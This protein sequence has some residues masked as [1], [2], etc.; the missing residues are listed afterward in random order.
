MKCSK[1]GFDLKDSAKFCPKCGAEVASLK[2]YCAQCGGELEAGLQFCPAC[3]KKVGNKKP[4]FDYKKLTGIGAGVVI[5]AVLALIVGGI[6]IN[7]E[8]AMYKA[9]VEFKEEYCEK[10]AKYSELN[11]CAARIIMSPDNEKWLAI[12]DVTN[13][14]ISDD[15]DI[16]NAAVKINLY[17]Y[18]WGKVKKVSSITKMAMWDGALFSVIDNEL[19]LFM[20]SRVYDFGEINNKKVEGVYVLNADNKFENVKVSKTE[21]D[22]NGYER[23]I[24]ESGRYLGEIEFLGG[25]LA[26]EISD[27]NAINNM[28]SIDANEF[29]TVVEELSNYKI[30]N[31]VDLQI[32]YGNILK[33]VGLF[34]EIAHNEDIFSYDD[35]VG[36]IDNKYGFYYVR[37]SGNLSLIKVKDGCDFNKVL[38]SVD[39]RKVT[40][41]E[42]YCCEG[43]DVPKELKIP[44]TI[45]YIGDG[46]FADQYAI[47]SVEL[48][49]SIISIGE[50]AF[51]NCTKLQQIEI[52]DSVKSI[53]DDAFSSET[54]FW[55]TIIADEESYAC[56]YARENV[57]R[58]SE[59]KLNKEELDEIAA[60][61][62]AL[63][64]YRELLNSTDFVPDG[65]CSGVSLFYL[66][67]DIVPEL[68]IWGYEHGDWYHCVATV[69]S[70]IN[71]NLLSEEVPINQMGYHDFKYMPKSGKF[72]CGSWHNGSG[73]VYE[74]YSLTDK[75]EN[76]EH[77]IDYEAA[78][79]DEQIYVV[80]GDDFDMNL[81]SSE[82]V[83]QYLQSLKFEAGFSS[84]NIYSSIKEAY[85]NLLY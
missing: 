48:P 41:L 7:S 2:K 27:Y 63:D 58:W 29:G 3:G 14:V 23:Y 59:K 75:F 69:Y 49:D 18:S 40:H 13:A 80:R 60:A 54:G 4:A 71:G 24:L 47:E 5:L 85:E 81:E 1:C 31:Q 20:E 44:N 22:D 73:A 82:G 19:Y 35:P 76:I 10:N 62:E 83:K 38:E 84:D 68:I 12:M 66:N 50:C 15:G 56:G 72:Y 67:A 61:R 8:K 51:Y 52:P 55:S 65:W 32:A 70:Y 79:P 37:A 17:K 77:I 33:E 53:G 64:V 43:L 30:K 11:D 26:G 9:Y 16:E 74:M 78:R 42:D 45:I 34:P 6:V 57:L 21:I 25:V 28:F 39:G 46:V 36:A